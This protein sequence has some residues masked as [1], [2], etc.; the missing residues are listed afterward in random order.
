MAILNHARCC[1]LVLLSVLCFATANSGIAL[2]Q[3]K[4]VPISK[5]IPY[6]KQMRP[7]LEEPVFAVCSK[8]GMRILVS[9]DD[10]KTWKQTFLGTDSEEDGGWHGTFAVYGMADTNGVIGVFSGCGTPGVYVGSDD[11][12]N[13]SHL[14]QQP[15]KLGSVWSATA[16]NKIFLTSSDQWR[17]VTS[18][19]ETV[20]D[21]QS[22][23][24]KPVLGDGKTH[25][26]IS[27]FGNY[28]GGRF[29]VVGDN[30][31]VFY[32]DDNC[33]TWKHSRIPESAGQKQDVVTFGNGVFLVSYPNHV[34]RSADGGVTWT[35]HEHGL[36]GWGKAWRGL[37]F[38]KGE[39]WLTA[40]KGSHARRSKDGIVWEDLPKSTPG[41]R[42]VTS[43]TGTIINVGRGLYDIK[44]SED[45]LTWKTVFT[46]PKKDVTWDM[47]F[48]V[49]QKVNR[50]D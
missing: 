21:F 30:R 22:H 33:Q 39:F 23:N 35:V 13:W 27:G 11:G 43:G 38:V 12:R 49:H 14:I 8:Q 34:A 4:H 7:R 2:A 6:G 16:G 19:N 37:S 36:K 20:S 31:H 18:S 44:R 46:A 26:M 48:A 45:G 1:F 41:G 25:H 32:S 24:I 29:V 10:G 17:G 42:F 9:R 50:V 40:K 28:T 47:S 3:K 5:H 15:R